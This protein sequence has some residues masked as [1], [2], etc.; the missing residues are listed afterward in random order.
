MTPAQYLD[1]LNCLR[2]DRTN[3]RPRPYGVWL[4]LPVLDLGGLATV[5]VCF[6]GRIT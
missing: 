6:W 2:M 1:Q 5:M 4:L 3:D